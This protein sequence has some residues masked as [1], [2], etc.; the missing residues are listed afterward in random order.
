MFAD[1][2]I[3]KVSGEGNM[4]PVGWRL[5]ARIL[6]LVILAAQASWAADI[7][8]QSVEAILPE[9]DRL[10]DQTLKKTGVPGM[11]IAVVCKDQVIHQKGYGVREAGKEERVD[12][13]T[14]FQLASVSKPMASTVLAAL[15]GE[16]II[17]WDDRVIDHDPSFRLSDSFVTREVTLRD[18]LCHRSGLPD[19]AGDLLEDLGCDRTEVLRRLRFEKPASS[20]RSQFAYTNFGFTQAAVAGARAAGGAWEDLAADKLFGPLGM[21]SSSFRFA[22]YAAA[23]NRAR[24]HVRAE[25]KWVARYSRQPDAQAPAGGASSTA[26]DLSQWLRL[27]L[28]GG[29]FAGKQV[30][31][32]KA[33]AETHRPQIISHPPQDPATNRAG[34]Y[35]LGWN[36]NYD[37]GDRVRLG[38]S[39]AFDL[40]A[41]TAVALLP[42][43]SLGIVVLTNA[44]PFGVPEAISASF[45][46]LVLKGKIEKDWLE[47]FRPILAALSQPAY[48]TTA[49]YTKPPASKSPP[50]PWATYQGTYRNDYYGDLEVVEQDGALLLRIGPKM[51]SF[52]LRHWDC[53]IFIYQPE[54]E[55][56]GG[57]SAVTFLVGPG[58]KAAR[59]VVENLDVHG[60]GTFTRQPATE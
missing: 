34:F 15:V 18:L 36:V 56:A 20:F 7:T 9:L 10:A 23:Q 26:R 52:A 58:R 29:K 12:I 6:C 28:A 16:G 17:D 50:L 55:M 46:D 38:H 14:I 4:K 24:L 37:D 11:A 25:G 21:K 33:L 54:G 51:N 5:L 49:D 53:D 3:F 57:P 42:A 2:S 32:A 31:A 1:C 41:A 44:A 47:M 27:H 43:E 60:Q 19:H 48:G 59:A 45:F 30:V 35:G 40:G 13:D 22:D 39:G 8:P